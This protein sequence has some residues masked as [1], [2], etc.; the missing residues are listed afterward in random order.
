[1]YSS[2]CF[3]GR[4]LE[5]VLRCTRLCAYKARYYFVVKLRAWSWRTADGPFALVNGFV[6]KELLLLLKRAEVDEL[7]VAE[8]YTSTSGSRD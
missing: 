8:I 4:V 7:L 6:E 3:W 1:M 5:S 2:E